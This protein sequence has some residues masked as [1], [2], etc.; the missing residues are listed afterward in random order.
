MFDLIFYISVGKNGKEIIP[1]KD[2]TN[3]K[4]LRV[5]K[6]ILMLVNFVSYG[7]QKLF[8]WV[9]LLKKIQIN[10]KMKKKT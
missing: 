7:N 1:N 10:C 5:W 6:K 3:E 8:L 4:Q 2:N 9:R